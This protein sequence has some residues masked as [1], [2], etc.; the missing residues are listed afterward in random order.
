[1]K[2]AHGENQ[3]GMCLCGCAVASPFCL[4]ACTCTCLAWLHESSVHAACQ[5]ATRKLFLGT[6][7]HEAVP[8]TF[9]AALVL[10]DSQPDMYTHTTAVFV[11]QVC[12]VSTHS[13]G[14]V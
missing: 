8:E 12:V 11:A 7:A 5:V 1:M 10:D 3:P 6:V 9:C 14:T 13:I 2:L 4:G